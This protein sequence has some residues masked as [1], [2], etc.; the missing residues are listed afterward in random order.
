MSNTRNRSVRAIAENNDPV[1]RLTM[2][3]RPDRKIPARSE[4]AHLLA[5]RPRNSSGTCEASSMIMTQ[6]LAKR[7][8]GIK[9]AMTSRNFVRGSSRWIGVFRVENLNP[10]RVLRDNCLSLAK[11]VF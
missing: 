7:S 8:A 5:T 4:S 1:N 6:T 2:K 9:T 10:S 11:F 3:M